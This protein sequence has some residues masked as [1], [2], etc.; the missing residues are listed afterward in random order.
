MKWELEHFQVKMDRLDRDR[1]SDFSANSSSGGPEVV[2]GGAS[3]LTFAGS[4]L[5]STREP[6]ARHRFRE[7]ILQQF[8]E[9]QFPLEESELIVKS[10]EK[11]VDGR[12]RATFFDGT[13]MQEVD[14]HAIEPTVGIMFMA[15]AD[16]PRVNQMEQIG[17]TQQH[18]DQK[19]AS[20]R[21][22]TAGALLK[23][24]E[25]D[26]DMSFIQTDN[27]PAVIANARQRRVLEDGPFINGNRNSQALNL[28]NREDRTVTIDSDKV[29][30]VS[31]LSKGK[32]D[33]E[34]TLIEVDQSSLVN[35]IFDYRDL[36][37]REG[38]AL[39]TQ[40][41]VRTCKPSAT[42]AC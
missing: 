11:T 13:R 14:D 30:I 5:V 33:L 23:N 1:D 42:V 25:V 41:T 2:G 36:I 6:N 7:N 32:W 31:D 4:D 35:L 22:N 24:F 28:R 12:V 3:E 19:D 17:M 37:H 18:P 16:A 8:A 34:S 27:T 15:G 39:T 38:P 10:F 29:T 40:D 9:K 26:T 20:W 21:V